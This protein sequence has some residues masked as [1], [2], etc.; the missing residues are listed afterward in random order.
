[1]RSPPSVSDSRACAK[2]EHERWTPRPGRRSL[3]R[4]SSSEGG[5]GLDFPHYCDHNNTGTAQAD[6]LDGI[7]GTHTV[8]AGALGDL[9]E[10]LGECVGPAAIERQERRMRTLR[11]V[12]ERLTQLPRALFTCE[13]RGDCPTQ[14]A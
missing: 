7:S 4:K 13:W 3:P 2:R 5:G 12:E 8:I 14:R 1:M 6:D 10:V 11:R 9:A